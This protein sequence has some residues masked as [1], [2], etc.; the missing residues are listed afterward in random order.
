MPHDTISLIG[1]PGA[2]K[3]TVGVLLAKALGYGFVDSDIVIQTRHGA[4]LQEILDR[5]G[6]LHLRRLEEEV[7]LDLPLERQ[8]LATG[9]SAVYSEAGMKRLKAAGPVAFIDVP[10][11]V[12]TGRVDNED[13]RGIARAPGQS[14]GDVFRERQ[15]LYRRYADIRIDDR[16]QPAETVARKL[17]KRLGQP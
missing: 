11:D 5:H 9:G 7:L 13:S 1:M 15:P 10:L 16:G 3:S 6:H 4:T 14:F 2:G 17:A 8:L 12:L